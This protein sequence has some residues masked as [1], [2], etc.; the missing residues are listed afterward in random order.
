MHPACILTATTKQQVHA[1][2]Q[3]HSEDASHS[4]SYHAAPTGCMQ[5]S[6]HR[7]STTAVG[8]KISRPGSQNRQKPE[9]GAHATRRRSRTN[10]YRVLQA[11]RPCRSG[12]SPEPAQSPPKARRRAAS[13]TLERRP[14][15]I[16]PHNS[17]PRHEENPTELEFGGKF[18][19]PQ[20]F[21][22]VKEHALRGDKSPQT[23]SVKKSW[24]EFNQYIFI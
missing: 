12:A 13:A 21:S 15:A 3:S 6:S 1:H 5:M 14:L 4:H 9:T 11:G 17:P 8:K 23:L 24:A 18:R 7:A 10:G 19:V 2:A 16:Q 22:L 20:T